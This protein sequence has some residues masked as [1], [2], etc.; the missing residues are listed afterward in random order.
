MKLLMISQDFPPDVGGIQTY[1]Q[2]LADRF[3]TLA[4]KFSVLVPDRPGAHQADSVTPYRIYRV[5]SQNA[6]LPVTSMP[7]V[8]N[9]VYNAGYN[10]TFHAQWQ[11]IL[12]TYQARRRGDIKA[13]FCAAHGRELM[14]NP[15]KQGTK[16][17]DLYNRFR[18]F[19]LKEADHFFAVSN[20]NAELLRGLGVEPGRITVMPNGTN[21]E[22][23]YPRDVSDLRERMNLQGKKVIMSICRL[24]RRKG[25]DTVISAFS[26]ISGS[27]PDTEMVIIGDG[28]DRLRLESL[29]NELGISQS[30]RF[31][32]WVTHNEQ[33]IN[34]FYNLADIVVMTPR[35]DPIQVEGFGIVYLEANSCE[36]PV[37]G[38]RS[39]G[40]PDAVLEGKT[41]LLVKEN[42]T[43]ELADAMIRLL[44]D[45]N[46]AQRLGRVGRQR[47]LNEL[48][49]DS[50]SKNI[51][52]RMNQ[53]VKNSVA[54]L[55][56]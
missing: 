20:Y 2:E 14:F 36:K 23:F 35:T 54:S 13:I 34:Q 25:V 22:Q 33:E 37:I 42:N 31:M 27:H 51:Y 19:L 38:S 48:N 56:R 30:V 52:D 39:G 3:V 8:H 28:P 55:N 32:G 1:C 46:F 4:H 7:A 47:V 18:Q 44:D 12:S 26:K 17:H 21:P 53:I 24:V 15:A 50:I 29:V 11:T 9:L 40:I 5:H 43:D 6:W 45:P 10:V 16:A 41:G 49:W